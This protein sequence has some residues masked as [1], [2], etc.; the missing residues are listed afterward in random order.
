MAEGIPFVGWLGRTKYFILRRTSLELP[1]YHIH[2]RPKDTLILDAIGLNAFGILPES[3]SIG[4]VKALASTRRIFVDVGANV[5]YYTLLAAKAG[6]SRVIAFEPDSSYVAQL[7]INLE[8]NNVT[9]VEIIQAIV[10]GNKTKR[11]LDLHKHSSGGHRAVESEQGQVSF[12]LS[13]LDIDWDNAVVK[14][15]IEGLEEE[16]IRDLVSRTP[17]F[18][19]YETIHSD[20]TVFL[21]ENGYRTMHLDDNSLAILW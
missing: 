16:V 20:A 18:I 4:A 1:M 19:V 8:S 13:D 3:Q 9:G 7:R 14:I 17:P 5:G 21:E 15:D 11:Q 2:A 12:L 6:Y 10:A